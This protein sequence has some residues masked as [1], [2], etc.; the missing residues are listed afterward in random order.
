MICDLPYKFYA[1]YFIQE[2]A[3]G[4]IK[5]GFTKNISSRFEALQVA[6]PRPLRILGIIRT[7]DT[8]LEKVWHERFAADCV[9]GEWFKPT[10]ALREAIHVESV[11]PTDEDLAEV[12][13]TR[14]KKRLEGV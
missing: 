3:S 13:L 2:G 1:V 10:S 8:K 4:P 14:N 11:P 12:Q 7:N 6:N 5:I 9:I